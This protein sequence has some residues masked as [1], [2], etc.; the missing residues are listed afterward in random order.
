MLQIGDTLISLDIIDKKFI[1][2][3]PKCLG[4]CCEHGDS[5]APL[6]DEEAAII[7]AEYISIKP[8]L[9]EKGIK[10]IEEIGTSTIDSDGDLVT[11]LIDNKECSFTVYEKGI[12]TCGIERAWENGDCSLQKPISCHL[13]PI[14]LKKYPTFT[15]VNYDEWDVCKPALLLGRKENLPLYKFLKTPL[16]RKFGDD[17]YAELELA[18]ESLAGDQNQL[19]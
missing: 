15:A 16:I 13:Y 10:S 5:G 18:A 6:E 8:Y 1:C 17:W 9:S 7:K 4:K 3:V 11:T 12:A 14:R 19:P 2:D